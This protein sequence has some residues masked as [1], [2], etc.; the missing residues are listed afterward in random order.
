MIPSSP[1]QKGTM[2]HRLQAGTL[3]TVAVI[4]HLIGWVCVLDVPEEV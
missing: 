2:S 3:I 1:W 4:A